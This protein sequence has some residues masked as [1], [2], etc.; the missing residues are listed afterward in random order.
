MK[1]GRLVDEFFDQL[2]IA[3]KER[4]KSQFAYP[5]NYIME[6]GLATIY[7][8]GKT[9]ATFKSTHED[10]DGIVTYLRSK[11][12]LGRLF[13]AVLKEGINSFLN[14]FKSS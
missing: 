14:K 6:Q 8:V 5:E 9:V 4:D 10:L 13:R 3:V 7:E 11:Y 12:R 1:M 2:Q